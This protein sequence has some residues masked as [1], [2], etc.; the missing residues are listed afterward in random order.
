[1]AHSKKAFY[2]FTIAGLFLGVILLVL[3]FITSDIYSEIVK[4]RELAI[5]QRNELIAQQKKMEKQFEA[6]KNKKL[7][8][9]LHKHFSED[10]FLDITKTCF[11]YAI[12][13]NGKLIGK[14]NVFMDISCDECIIEVIE[15]VNAGSYPMEILSEISPLSGRKHNTK[16]AISV[17]SSS[18]PFTYKVSEFAEKT[19]DIYKFS[20]IKAGETITIRINNQAVQDLLGL[21][22]DVIEITHCS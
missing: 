16:P 2:F 22:T 5:E 14:D 6:A 11:R 18:T 4:R 10:D 17:F 12:K 15:T 20:D 19:I 1:M 13:F 21:G 8:I 9:V 3:I 7:N